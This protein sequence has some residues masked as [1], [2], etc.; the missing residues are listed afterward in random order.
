MGPVPNSADNGAVLGIKAKPQTIEPKREQPS[1]DD[2]K[3]ISTLD[4][5]ATNAEPINLAARGPAGNFTNVAPQDDPV[6]PSRRPT[7]PENTERHL[8]ICY[9]P[10]G[11]GRSE[12][13]RRRPSNAARRWRGED[14]VRQDVSCYLALPVADNFYWAPRLRGHDNRTTYLRLTLDWTPDLAYPFDTFNIMS[15]HPF[16]QI[17][18]L[19]WLTSNALALES[20]IALGAA[21]GLPRCGRRASQ[22]MAASIAN[23]CRLINDNLGKRGRVSAEQQQLTI[24]AI[25]AMG[26][27]AYWDLDVL[28]W[29]IHMEGLSRYLEVSGGLRNMDDNTLNKIRL[30]DIEG[31]LLAGQPPYLKFERRLPPMPCPLSSRRQLVMISTL[32]PTLRACNVN[33]DTVDTVIAVCI[34][35][36]TLRMY[37]DTIISEKIDPEN[38]VEDYYY[39]Q[40]RLLVYPSPFFKL[41]NDT[42]RT[43]MSSYVTMQSHVE[44]AFEVALRICMLLYLRAP[45]L[46]LPFR[47]KAYSGLLQALSVQLRTLLEFL[48]LV[49]GPC[50]GGVGKVKLEE[51]DTGGFLVFSR[52]L[53]LWMCMLGSAL[54]HYLNCYHE[55][56]SDHNPKGSVYYRLLNAL[57]IEC[58][59]D[60]DEICEEDLEICRVLDLNWA[61]KG[62]WDE[63]KVLR[64]IIKVE[65]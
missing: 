17:D 39:L 44:L 56:W 7:K 40:Y 35:S 6:N 54:S 53:L 32:R 43:D 8:G 2:A 12:A 28:T 52:P 42:H 41:V 38:V 51:E 33:D 5:A 55:G 22:T 26:I 65:E 18:K 1:S 34:F 3:P 29:R 47:W 59:S 48:C 4:V 23:T 58:L 31:A 57:G 9:Q 49:Q 61:R 62:I 36:W 16:R 46:Q 14:A 11:G 60:V 15:H 27:T 30:V 20:S 13:S 64:R 63:K 19:D 24:H 21:I 45:T 10:R 50:L 37:R 25:C